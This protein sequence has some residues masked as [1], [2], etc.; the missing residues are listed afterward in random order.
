[1]ESSA[2]SLR[3]TAPR[4]APASASFLDARFRRAFETAAIGFGICDLDGRIIEANPALAQLLGYKCEEL[5]GVDPWNLTGT[6]L[7]GTM[8]AGTRLP[9]TP[10]AEA[11]LAG[12]N[13][14]GGKAGRTGLAEAELL[15]AAPL[16][17][18]PRSKSD[19]W[20][21]ERPCQRRDGS[22][23]CGRVT[24]SVA[25][26]DGG[27]PVFLVVLLEDTG[28]R[29]HTDD[30]LRQAEK[31]ELIGRLAAGVAHD[32]NNL[33]TGILLYCDLLLPSFEVDEP[34]HRY[35][36]EIRLASEQGAALTHQLLAIAR[37]QEPAP[38]SGMNE[39]VASSENL[40][41]RL[42]GER[43]ELITALDARA[44]LLVAD[45]A[46]LRQLL[47]NLVLNARDALDQGK[48]PGGKIW[49][50]TRV[51]RWPPELEREAISLTVEDN[52]CGMNAETC[53]HLFEP[54]FTTK[55]A[56]E[57]TGMG[58]GTVQRIVDELGGSIQISSTPGSGTRVEV[59][60]PAAIEPREPG[61]AESTP[62]AA[63]ETVRDG[64]EGQISGNAISGNSK[65][66][67]SRILNTPK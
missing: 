59:L 27:Q 50:S 53:S 24:A 56:S 57:G 32:F 17:G 64:I 20:V 22:G 41:R 34:P 35:V 42:M 66:L 6:K 21:V 5:V 28:E 12:P 47:M 14:A 45:G 49:V 19:S 7:V 25:R 54:F 9:E 48:V 65:V 55:I 11:H 1:M 43:I 8:L 13:F 44:G 29:K 30:R 67:N 4:F 23:F 40:L 2:L 36:E 61:L 62:V 46:R 31:M 33:L 58:L 18:L 63:V 39:I 37:K 38:V 3:S 26:D 10:S 52:G 15:C 51:A 60:L 16:D